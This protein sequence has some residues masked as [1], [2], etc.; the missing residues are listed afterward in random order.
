MLL[1]V[2]VHFP[3]CLQKC[4]YC[5]FASATIRRDEVPHAAYADAVLRELAWR[6]GTIADATLAS[7]YFGGG[8]PSLWDAS[9]LGRV[10][11]AVRERFP[12]A[13][14]PLEVTV[15][16]NPSS[17]DAGRARALVGAG[18]SRLSIGVQSLDERRLRYLGRLHDAEGALTAVRAARSAIDNVSADLMFGMP[19]LSADAAAEYARRLAD[20][21][22][23]HLSVYALTIEPNTQ[24]GQL[25]AKGRL[26]V[27]PDEMFAASFHAVERALGS[28]GFAHYEVS[29]YAR[30]GRESAHNRHYWRGGAYL[31]LGAGA[32][33]CVHT[34]PG[35]SRRYRNDPT[36]ARYLERSGERTVEVSDEALGVQELVRER[37]MLGL[38]TSDGIDLASV[39]E[40]I[41]VDPLEGRHAAVERALARGNLVRV[42]ERLRVPHERWLHLDGIIASVF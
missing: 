24:F 30:A 4:P 34:G 10:L 14:E 25:H 37:W 1:S 42:G 18:A 22:V 3:W 39:R 28:V 13:I 33:G 5:D 19:G 21:D 41:G 32:V 26:E 9:E 6:A 35:A 16:C 7:V 36:P 17:L 23:A 12:R 11:R 40:S 38:R 27:A 2:Y 15:E 8:T 31:G 29:S 20:L